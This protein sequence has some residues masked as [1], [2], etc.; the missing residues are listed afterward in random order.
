MGYADQGLA[1]QAT[2]GFIKTTM[3]APLLTREHELDLARRWRDDEDEAALHELVQA[4][5]RLVVSLA[6]KLRN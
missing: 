4:Y 2:R 1:E 6:V 5:M 3:K